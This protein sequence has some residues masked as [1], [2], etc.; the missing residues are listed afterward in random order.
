MSQRYRRYPLKSKNAKALLGEISAKLKVDMDA[1]FGSKANVEVVEAEFGKVYLV[2]GKALFFNVGEK[3]LPTLLFHE[4]NAQAP[5]VVVDM[6]A[7]PYICKGADVMAPG[8]IR[9]EGKFDKGD[10]VLVTDEKYGK[11]LALGESLMDAETAKTAKQ[12]AVVKNFHFVSDK[13]WN[14][15]KILAEQ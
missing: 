10:V 1:I 5:K 11:S 7:V 3:T 6:G 2:N 9:F 15:A 12:G 4:F 8:I 13:I 14:L